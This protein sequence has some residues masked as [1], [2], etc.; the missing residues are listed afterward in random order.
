MAIGL[1]RESVDPQTDILLTENTFADEFS[2]PEFGNQPYNVPPRFTVT[3]ELHIPSEAKYIEYIIEGAVI[4]NWRLSGTQPGEARETT[5][6][7]GKSIGKKIRST[8][9]V[10]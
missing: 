7:L 4:E 2:S 6:F 8:S 10:N 5:T 9:T 1:A 3:C